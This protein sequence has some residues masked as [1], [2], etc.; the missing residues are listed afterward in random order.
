MSGMREG[1]G[2]RGLGTDW[3]AQVHQHDPGWVRAWQRGELAGLSTWH[4]TEECT[5]SSSI[6]W[7]P[8]GCGAAV[9]APVDRH[10]AG[11]GHAA[12]VSGAPRGLRIPPRHLAR[13][14]A[15]CQ[16]LRKSAAGESPFLRAHYQQCTPVQHL[17]SWLSRSRTGTA[18]LPPTAASPGPPGRGH[19]RGCWVPR[20]RPHGPAAW[21]LMRPLSDRNR[22]RAGAKPSLAPPPSPSCGWPVRPASPLASATTREGWSALRTVM[23]LLT[24][25]PEFSLTPR[26]R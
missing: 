12:G 15:A 6:P 9:S 7:R 22:W 18:R 20:A 25:L 17:R 24:D 3:L 16:I 5:P 26:A 10:T 21:T 23:E 8:R 13:L 11:H 4:G 2:H 1:F 14:G 19:S